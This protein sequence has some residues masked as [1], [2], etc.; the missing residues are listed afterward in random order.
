M[1]RLLFLFTF[2][3]FFS[4][5]TQAGVWSCVCD[6]L[7]GKSAGT[8][9]HTCIPNNVIENSLKLEAGFKVKMKVRGKEVEGIVLDQNLDEVVLSV[10]GKSQTFKA[11]RV[12]D[13]QFIEKTELIVKPYI[14]ARQSALDKFNKQ[15][16]KLPKSL[17]SM[18]LRVTQEVEYLRT[19][20]SKESRGAYLRQVGS[21]IEERIKRKL[22]T[23]N[24][25]YHFN[26]NGGLDYEYAQAGGIYINRGD[27]FAQHGMS[28]HTAE[29]VYFFQSK[30]VGLYDL[31]NSYDMRKILNSGRMGDTLIMFNLD[32]PYFNRALQEK[33]IIGVSDI[34]YDFDPSWLRKQSFNNP[35]SG[36]V[37]GIPADTFVTSPLPLYRKS[38]YKILGIKSPSRE[39][40]NIIYMRLLEDL[41]LG[42]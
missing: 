8:S 28:S 20:S 2:S 4:L 1:N 41:I 13:I 25:G 10:N 11:S 16:Q 18:Q 38:H 24:L 3:F 9:Y 32:H 19:L 14:K 5:N 31:V 36:R 29:N 6:Y 26:L 39:E 17:A 15:L 37:I 22:G 34:Y 21:E 7:S 27:I 42:T 30:K 23:D 12:S 40:Q 33:G 35:S